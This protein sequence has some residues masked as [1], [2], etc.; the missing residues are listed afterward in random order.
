MSTK[1]ISWYARRYVE[2]FGFAL[3]PL[4]PESKLPLLNDWGHNTLNTPDDAE[5]Y[6]K[7][8]PNHNIGLALGPSRMCSLDI[9][10][11]DSFTVIMNEF[12]IPL[13][14]LDAFPTIQGASKGNRVMF[15]IPEGSAMRYAKLNWP[16]V[17]DPT[18]DIH[19]RVMR[20][21]SEAKKE[22]NKKR[23][24]R[25]RAIGK[26]YRIYT[27][28]ELRADTDDKQ[29][30]DV[31][32]PSIHP[33]THQPYVWLK[34]PKDKWPEPPA[35]LL[36]IWEAWDCFKPQ[37]QDA[38]PWSKPAPRQEPKKPSQP[39]AEGA[40][41]I[42]QYIAAHPLTNSLS[43]YGYK[44]ITKRWLSPHSGT[45]LPGVVVYP[46]GERCW[47]H[48]ASDPL[49]SDESG[50][51]V[52]SFDLY[53]YYDHGGDVSKAVKAAA[54]SLGLKRERS[55]PATPPALSVVPKTTK[56]APIPA[57]PVTYSGPPAPFIALGYNGSAYYYLPRGTE[58][59]AEIRRGSHTSPAEMM[60]LASVEWWE[61]AFPK[62]K[63]GID[64]F[65]AASTCM[66]KCENRGIYTE[67]RER[68]RGSWYDNGRAVLHLGDR[69]LI[70]GADT[71]IA[72]HDSRF[73]YTR[74][75]PLELGV[76]ASPLD[77]AGAHKVADVFRGL[78]WA[79][80]VH[81]DLAM[82]WTVLA[83]ICGAL[84][85]RPHIWITAQRGAGK[86]WVQD[87]IINPLLGQCAM[88]VQGSTS[89]AGIRQRMRQDARPII[90]DEAES[91]NQ[92][93]QKRMQAVIE[94][95]R[96]S[97]SDSSAE[98]VKGTASGGGM[99]FRMRSMFLLGSVNVSL[100]QAADESRF[101]VLSL[102]PP[103]KSPAEI[104][105]FD[106]FSRDVGNTLT[107]EFCAALR[108]RSYLMMPTI[109]DNAKTFAR[110]VAEELGSQRIGDQIG[111]LMAGCASLYSIE[112]LTL[113]QARS[114]VAGMD[115]ADA[116]EAE[117]ASDEE[118]CLSRIMQAQ[119]QFDTAS[120]GMRRSIGELVACAHGDG[121]LGAMAPVDANSILGRYGLMVEGSY[122]VVSN[123]H[124][125]LAKLLADS[126]W[127]AGW[128]RVLA[129][130]DGANP[131][132]LAVRFAGV[133]SRSIR[134][135]FAFI[136]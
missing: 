72:D 47:I 8:N 127:A 76:A 114:H 69:L 63:G 108:A 110:A 22:G 98:I 24:S 77:D 93:S 48:H 32:P 10:C 23:E 99:A 84:R 9:D 71:Q 115:L 125:E 117:Q 116:R 14:E 65:Q 43:T 118:S 29:R 132:P 5:E 79:N 83:P 25:L 64:W 103:E 17:N 105:R 111:T 55:K 135:P 20:L 1:N 80:P 128:R 92:G 31:L 107:P 62:E 49:C 36:A 45:G 51:P 96:Q 85:W 39:A 44:Q 38:C 18:G 134:V 66:R 70:D 2:R 54:D 28:F 104:A 100:S 46:C 59:V 124:S 74:Q 35:W 123:T 30:F 52:N 16:S 7:A 78:N 21:A 13:T 95:A 86:S 133:R 87:N 15:R 102:R 131:S 67:E 89:E 122:I 73:I 58:Q 37:L 120:G 88:V 57:E 19:K 106:Q 68:G 90:F 91:E 112:V 126:P 75:A 11:M 3:V 129:R 101:S 119:V 94:L 41:V 82:G 12:G 26:R 130:V 4:K 34:Q 42:D 40:S 113:E 33:D 53:C 61:A 27:V 97:S 136:A 56:T 121:G 6:Y 81:A 50:K 60:S 109:R